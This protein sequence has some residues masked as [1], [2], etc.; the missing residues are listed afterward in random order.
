MTERIPQPP[1]I[2]P[3]PGG[4]FSISRTGLS[5]LLVDPPNC[6]RIRSANRL[7]LRP[8]P[9]FDSWNRGQRKETQP[10]THPVP[11]PSPLPG[12]KGAGPQMSSWKTRAFVSCG[13]KGK[14][15]TAGWDRTELGAESSGDRVSVPGN[16]QETPLHQPVK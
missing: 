3:G 14:K 4:R 1:N 10:L 9:H 13:V 15:S 16:E 7:H 5:P 11:L 12:I 2:R 6:T 8:G